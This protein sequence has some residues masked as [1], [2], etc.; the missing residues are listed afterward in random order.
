M[1][2]QPVVHRIPPTIDGKRRVKPHRVFPIAVQIVGH[3]RHVVQQ[4]RQ[5]FDVLDDGG[6]GADDGQ[7]EEA[8]STRFGRLFIEGAPDNAE[9]DGEAL[10]VGIGTTTFGADRVFPVDIAAVKDELP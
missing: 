8:W 9:Q 5:L 3:Q 6:A 2:S 4:L 7:E 10:F 1:Q